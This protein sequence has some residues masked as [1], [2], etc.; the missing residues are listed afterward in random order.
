MECLWSLMEVTLL[1]G[2]SRSKSFGMKGILVF[3]ALFAFVVVFALDV[4]LANE[5]LEVI[6]ERKAFL[7]D[8]KIAVNEE[9]VFAF[10]VMFFVANIEEHMWTVL[11]RHQVNHCGS[12][13]KIN[14][15]DTW[16]VKFKATLCWI[17][18]LFLELKVLWWKNQLYK[19]NNII[20]LI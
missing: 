19:I 6:S 1:N 17:L 12:G 5:C 14:F 18:L 4:M 13:E 11:R 20:R 10:M 7:W 16:V 15:Y 3:C 9:Q 8:G 2:R